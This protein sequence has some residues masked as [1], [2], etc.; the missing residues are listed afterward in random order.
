MEIINQLNN[1]GEAHDAK[2]YDHFPFV[3]QL[4]PPNHLL[5]KTC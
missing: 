3:P 5:L 2:N 4:I 1:T